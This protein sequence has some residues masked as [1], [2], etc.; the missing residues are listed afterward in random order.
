M[1]EQ[2]TDRT[3]GT[4]EE[5]AKPE[6][7]DEQY[8]PYLTVEDDPEGTTDE[9]E[10]LR[11]H[12][13]Q[14]RGVATTRTASR[15]PRVGLLDRPTPSADAVG[16]GC[17][18]GTLRDGEVHDTRRHNLCTPTFGTRSRARLGVIGAPDTPVPPWA[19]VWCGQT[20]IDRSAA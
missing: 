14:G 6:A 13:S 8:G 20:G 15:E 17:L 7:R 9:A 19:I 1:S 4:E 3:A 5:A 12:T 18:S 16:G 10:L 11:R 2:P